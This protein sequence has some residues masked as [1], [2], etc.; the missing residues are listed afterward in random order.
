[1]YVNRDIFLDTTCNDKTAKKHIT[2]ATLTSRFVCFGSLLFAQHPP[3]C[4]REE[5]FLFCVR[6]LTSSSSPPPTPCCLFVMFCFCSWP[7][8]AWYHCPLPFFRFFPSYL[9]DTHFF[10]FHTEKR[11]GKEGREKKAKEQAHP[12]TP[13]TQRQR[14]D[15]YII[16][17]FRRRR[18]SSSRPWRRPRA[19]QRHRPAAGQSPCQSPTP[20]EG[21]PGCPPWPSGRS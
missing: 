15:T 6:L 19:H 9:F 4:R 20:G 14:G 2:N 3:H 10:P 12:I 18:G 1:M 8:A 16:R 11:E 21:G 5:L 17:R 7:L 13:H